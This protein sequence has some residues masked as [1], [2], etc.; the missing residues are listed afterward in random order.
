M[1][2]AVRTPPFSVAAH[3]ALDRLTAAGPDPSFFAALRSTGASWFRQHGLPGAKEEAW[4]FT[5]V[6]RLAEVPFAVA[7][8]VDV[9]DLELHLGPSGFGCESAHRVLLVNGRFRRSSHSGD[10]LELASLEQAARDGGALIA[11]YLGRLAPPEHAFAAL[12][13]ALLRDG[14]V[15]SVSAGVRAELPVHLGVVT[16]AQDQPAVDYPRLLVVVG[17]GSALSLVEWHL[18]L[19]G[20]RFLSAPVEEIVLEPGATL[21]HTRVVL[22]GGGAH[23]VGVVAVRQAERSR[24]FSTVVSLGG[25]LSRL[26]LGVRLCGE[27]ASAVLHGLYHA[28]GTEHVDHHT[29]LDHLAL[30]S[31]SQQV[32]RGIVDGLGRAV[33]DGTVFVRRGAQRTNAHQ[34][35][36]HLVLSDG[37]VVDTKP[38]LEIDADDVRCGHGATIGK[39]DP[40]QLF[41][42]RSRGLSEA[43][44][45][46]CLVQAFADDVLAKVP[47]GALRPT[48]A[49]KLTERLESSQPERIPP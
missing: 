31:S 22:A 28:H 29:T 18:E 6:E 19:G 14:I 16:V 24:Y 21:E 49:Q 38:R 9:D 30:G 35:N 20:G 48:L 26:D 46:A 5:P 12:N 40:E 2:L 17:A 15:V 45:R 27:G 10:G 23:R 1:T 32:Y 41:Y 34:L 42:L 3:A 7:Q 4:R 11:P 8:P 37:A 43:M 33:F 36:H 39:L 25:A 47:S 44:A 13:G